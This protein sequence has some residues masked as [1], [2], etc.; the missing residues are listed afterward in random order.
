MDDRLID[1]ETRFAF[2]EQAIAELSDVVARQ[3][4]EIATLGLQLEQLRQRLAALPLSD[5]ARPEEETPPPHY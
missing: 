1:L 5:I 2:Q 3:Q 4:Q